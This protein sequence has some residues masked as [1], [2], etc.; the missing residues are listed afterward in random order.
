MPTFINDPY[1]FT[2]SDEMTEDDIQAFKNAEKEKLAL[3]AKK[4]NKDFY[5][6][7]QE[8]SSLRWSLKQTNTKDLDKIINYSLRLAEKC[9]ELKRC[10]SIIEKYNNG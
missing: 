3:E 2:F 10:K 8:I 7:S 4:A 9:K 5:P 1:P 6:I